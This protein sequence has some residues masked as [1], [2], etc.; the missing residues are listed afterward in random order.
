MAE[1]HMRDEAGAEEALVAREGAVDELVD[2]HEGAGRQ[3]R[4]QAADGGERDEVG[5]AGALQRI[6]VG[7][8]IDL[9]RRHAMTAAVARQE[10]D[11]R[12]RERAET[13]LVRRLAEGRR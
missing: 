6:D 3:I 13:E 5:D 8:V 4:L 9:R 12:A 11:A 2:E 7:A 1:R 10:D